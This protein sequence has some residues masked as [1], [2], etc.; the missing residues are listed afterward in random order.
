M[1]KQTIATAKWQAKEGLASRSYKI[2]SAIA[3][4]FRDT[5]EEVERSQAEIL[6]T[7]MKAFVRGVEALTENGEDMDGKNI[8]LSFR[9]A[10]YNR[11]P[12][13]Q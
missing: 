13:A 11:K 6:S 12:Q 8:V 7:L 1:N 10:K 3:D 9:A 5:C 2:H 4:R